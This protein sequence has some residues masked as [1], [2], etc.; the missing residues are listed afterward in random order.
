MIWRLSVRPEAERDIA[1]AYDW[2]EGR[3][4]GLGQRFVAQVDAALALIEQ[5]PELHPRLHR[6]IRRVLTRRFPFGVFYIVEKES[7]VV[8]AVLHQASDPERWKSR[9]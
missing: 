2:Y 6:E 7:V 9:G 5:T 1:A 8:L 3:E 4:E